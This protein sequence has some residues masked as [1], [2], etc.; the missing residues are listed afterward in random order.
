M[1][2]KSWSNDQIDSAAFR[3][4]ETDI[5][6]SM[7]TPALDDEKTVREILMEDFQVQ[8]ATIVRRIQVELDAA[9][10]ED[11]ANRNRNRENWSKY[12]GLDGSQYSTAD[13][14][15][16]AS[17]GRTLDTFNIITQK[18]DSLAGS[19][20]KN[21]YDS[22]FVPVEPGIDNWTN[23]LSDMYLSDK[24]MMDWDAADGE[25]IISGLIFEGVQELYIDRKYHELGN[26]AWRTHLPGRI[27]FDPGWK[28][29]SAIDCQKCFR[30][31]Y[32]TTREILEWWPH[33][34]QENFRLL[35]DLEMQRISG[36]RWDANDRGV[37]P[38]FDLM[39]P[40][41]AGRYR[42]IFEYEMRD[43]EELVEVEVTTGQQLP[44]TSDIAI[45]MAWLDSINPDW[46]G[47]SVELR[48]MKK[49]VCWQTVICPEIAKW[50]IFERKPHEVQ[51]GRIPFFPWSAARINGNPRG[52]VDLI[53]DIQ[54]IIN[55]R[56]N[57]ISYVAMTQANG[58]MLIDP[59]LF[60]ND[61]K[62]IDDFIANKNKPNKII[63]TAP[64]A[65]GR[66]LAPTPVRSGNVSNEVITQLE[67]MWQYSDK[68]SKSPSVMDAQTASENESGYLYA[69]RTRMAE[70]QQFI[71]F[72]GIQRW[73][74][75]K[76]EAYMELVRSGHYSVDGIPRHFP[77]QGG[78]KFVTLNKKVK[79]ESGE[80]VIINDVSQIPRHKVAISESPEGL[81]NRMINRATSIDTLKVLP[82]EQIATRQ[83][84]ANVI[85]QSL[86]GLTEE[87]RQQLKEFTALE[88]QQAK[89][90]LQLNILQGEMQL[91]Q[92]SAP[93]TPP[94]PPASDAE[95]VAKQAAQQTGGV[96]TINF[97]ADASKL[98]PEP[99]QQAPESG[100]PSG[101]QIPNGPV[102]SSLQPSTPK[103]AQVGLAAAGGPGL[104]IPGKPAQ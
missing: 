88:T 6:S 53:K 66:N 68:L 101:A 40:S 75:E 63:R 99:A 12:A 89:I 52:I 49:K 65:L 8:Q 104:Q 54:D 76:A 35:A 4:D 56:E 7:G 31:A 42:V 84:V 29:G 103:G 79:S 67:R 24:D 5:N 90:K 20:M 22:T 44:K 30:V 58:A 93:P 69:Q 83:I 71:L 3:N 51:I 91:K 97:K 61:D 13:K 70:Q 50:V 38:N 19:I 82:P 16:A 18:V 95:S 60:N 21:P 23:I 2:K 78:K 39:I 73:Q 14:A 17:E 46:D 25:A 55:N 77:L 80:D 74:K 57:L 15:Q 94:A 43:E 37:T 92:L 86:D 72:S 96:V 98:P 32:M 102:P 48:P 87:Q 9:I 85:T 11:S 36:V 45:K 10:D 41:A 1:P 62:D 33:L 100:Q 26:A 27:V 59:L 64:G 28:T 81:T 34:A 47:N